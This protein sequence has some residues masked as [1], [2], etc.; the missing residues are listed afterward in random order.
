[1]SFCCCYSQAAGHKVIYL[2]TR[3]N[4]SLWK[5][6]LSVIFNDIVIRVN[7]G[8]GRRHDVDW[9]CFPAKRG[10]WLKKKNQLINVHKSPTTCLQYKRFYKLWIDFGPDCER[11]LGSF[12]IIFR[13]GNTTLVSDRCQ[14]VTL[15]SSTVSL[16]KHYIN[17]YLTPQRA[18]QSLLQSFSVR[19]FKQTIQ[20]H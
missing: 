15:F 3:L 10:S 16:Y 8:H 17:W 6:V 1:M 4:I 2:F 9:L 13:S 5:H 20:T 19:L 12:H 18:S 14:D 7:L 11:R